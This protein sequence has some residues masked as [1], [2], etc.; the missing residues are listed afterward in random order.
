MTRVLCALVAVALSGKRDPQVQ[1]VDGTAE[2]RRKFLKS[3]PAN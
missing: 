2:C 3:R 1:A